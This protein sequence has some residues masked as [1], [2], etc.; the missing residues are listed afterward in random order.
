[1]K[2]RVEEDPLG[3]RRIPSEA[4]YG[5]QTLRAA[6]NFPVSG[7]KAHPALIWAYACLKKACAMANLES[8]ALEPK[9]ARALLQACDEARQGRFD[10]HFIVDVYQAGA[11]TSFNMNV[12]EVLANRALELLGRRRG[13]YAVVHPNDHVN[14]AQSTNDTFPTAV[15]AAVLRQAALLSPI[16]ESLAGAFRTQGRRWR[17]VVKSARTH[18][19]D[20][21]P[22]TLGREFDAYA[23]AI[24]AARRQ[25]ERRTRLLRSVPLGGTVAGTGVNACRGFRGKAV[26]HL[27]RESALPLKPAGD[28]RLLLQSHQ[29]LTAVSSALKELA[30]E[31][32]RI[33]NDLR[34][35][36]SGPMTGLAEIELPAVQPGSSFL[37]GK[38]NPSLLEC[39]DMVC[40]Q[41]VGRDVAVSLAAHAGQLDL[42]VMTPLSA[43][44]LLDSLQM[45]IN[46]LP[47]VESRCIRGIRADRARCRDYAR[48]SLALAALLSPRL[49]Y[50]AAA[51]I[52]QEA[53]RRKVP[54]EQVVMERGCLKPGELDKLLDPSRWES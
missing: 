8:G 43:Y 5:V 29:P 2:T 9:L 34:L 24:L 40:F 50:A 51:K 32:I 12:N 16:L 54:A 21:V 7:L 1:M 14:M 52:V 22:I 6:E 31:L 48:K 49:G 10:R 39:L 17:K 53:R 26:R 20:A 37:P 38:V 19:Q 13:D 45:L 11:G 3:R 46:Y 23:A 35:L 47:V 15:Y 44:N 28:M 36:S 27:A 33:A 18:L 30:L 4:Y 42:N 41:I 25:L